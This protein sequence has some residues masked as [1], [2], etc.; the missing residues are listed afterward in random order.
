MVFLAIAPISTFSF[1]PCSCCA[2]NSFLCVRYGLSRAISS[3]SSFIRFFVVHFV[4]FLLVVLEFPGVS[5]SFLD[6]AFVS[7][8]PFL[9]AFASSLDISFVSY[10]PILRLSSIR[11]LNNLWLLSNFSTM[12]QFILFMLCI[13]SALNDVRSP[14]TPAVFV[15]NVHRPIIEHEFVFN[16]PSLN[17]NLCFIVWIV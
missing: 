9:R 7:Y 13:T 4:R 6:V 1:I 15:F 11:S 8:H 10:R 12:T 17:T 2:S 14:M 3:A 5:A 16:D